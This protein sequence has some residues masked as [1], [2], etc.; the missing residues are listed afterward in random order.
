[1]SF[2]GFEKFKPKTFIPMEMTRIYDGPD[3]YPWREVF[4]FLPRRSISGKLLFLEKAYK[5]RYWAVWG[6]GFHME[7][8]DEFGTLFDILKEDK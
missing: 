5:R 7:P 6:T 8:H 2:N 3:C 1:M 4:V